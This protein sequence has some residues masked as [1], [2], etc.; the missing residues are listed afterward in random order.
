ATR[1]RPNPRRGHSPLRRTLSIANS[2]PTN[3]KHMK[4]KAMKAR[5]PSC[6]ASM[7]CWAN[8]GTVL[9]CGCPAFGSD[10]DGRRFEFR[11]R[12][13]LLGP[14]HV[15]HQIEAEEEQDPEGARHDE[16]RLAHGA[17]VPLHHD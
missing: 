17:E 8:T 2:S 10:R 3:T 4:A 6:E 7:S 12:G 1:P 15:V 9:L 14:L 5:S 16:R 13:P 11:R